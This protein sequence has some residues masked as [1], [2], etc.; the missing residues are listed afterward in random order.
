MLNEHILQIHLGTLPEIDWQS[1]SKH[2]KCMHGRVVIEM[3]P[4]ETKRGVI[5]LPD[6]FARNERPDVGV[7]LAAG[8]DTG[9]VPGSCVVC[10]GGDG[11]WRSGFV[12][13]GYEAKGEV[14]CFGVFGAFQGECELY[15]WSDSLVAILHTDLSM[16]PLKKNLL[17]KRDATV[18]QDGSILLSE[19][20]TYRTNIG[21]IVNRGSDC[22]LPIGTRVIYH[23]RAM[24]ECD[25]LDGDPDLG[26]CSEDSIEAIIVDSPE[27]MQAV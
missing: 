3:A 21:T 24:L 19:N 2:I 7:V 20:A 1:A 4:A 12:A 16:T 11:T 25:I 23:P 27:V 17:I 22:E 8:Q 14:R 6:K 10:R 18:T 9:L 15:D 13:G 26:V 5:Y